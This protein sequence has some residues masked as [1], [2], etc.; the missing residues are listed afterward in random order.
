MTLIVVCALLLDVDAMK[1]QI[2]FC[3]YIGN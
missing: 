1:W 2:I 3:R